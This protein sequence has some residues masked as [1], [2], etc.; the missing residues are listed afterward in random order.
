[1]T[2]P[3]RLVLALFVLAAALLAAGCGG[4]SNVPTGSIAV[5]N[6]TQI[7]RSELDSWLTQAKK[8]Y[9]ATNQPFP[10]AGTAEYQNLQTQF[11]AAL[12]Q[13]EEFQQAAKDLGVTVTSKDIDKG[14][15]DYIKQKF[16][17]DRKKFE[18]ALK[19]QDFPES[20]FRK[21]ILVTVL[22]Q[23]IFEH[24]TKDVKV[25]TKD[26]QND[27]NQ[28]LAT[29]QQKASREVQYLV[30]KKTKP[31]G[32][33]DFPRCKK[34]VFDLYRRLRAGASFAALAKKYS[35]DRGSADQ[36][37]KVTFQKG[38]TVPEFEKVAFGLKTGQL[39]APVRSPT[40]GY[41]LM[42]PVTKITP[43]KTTP[44]SKVENA[45]KQ[46]L[47]QQKKQTVMYDWTQK[48]YKKYK[49]KISYA[50]G[51]APP[52]IPESTATSTQ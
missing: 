31:N 44:F 24:V 13:R 33:I 22:S 25:T 43:A 47:L 8:S 36:G 6:G 50:A 5:V 34:L 15:S 48:L 40:Y 37:G 38:Q 18:R 10:K 35:A 45:I 20:L 1:M 2:R 52:D 42:K 17:G 12:V 29:Y 9:Q 30:I 27:Y 19:A 23:K 16:G 26:A 51:F 32:Q 28:N 14:V 49:S 21:T 46:T 7:S 3:L 41:F 39:S 11:V 4:S